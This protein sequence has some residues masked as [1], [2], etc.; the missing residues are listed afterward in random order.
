VDGVNVGTWYDAGSDQVN[1]WRDSTFALPTSATNGKTSITVKVQFVSSSN[2]WNEFRYTAVVNGAA[3]D[4]L[5]VG[6][7]A[8][9]SAHHYVITTQTWTGTRTFTYP[10]STPSTPVTDSGRAHKGTSSF[11]LAVDPANRGVDLVRLLDHG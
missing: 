10:P 4:V 9:E 3:V 8:S 1:H 6:N 11:T 7:A 5:D 2:D